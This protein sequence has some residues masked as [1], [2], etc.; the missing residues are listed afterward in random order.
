MTTE[1]VPGRNAGPV[2]LY[3]LSTC[4]WCR[5]TRQLLDQMGVA[6]DYEYVDLVHGVERTA[7]MDLV[8]RWNHEGSFPT[9]VINNRAIVGFREN[10]IR[11]AL[12]PRE[13][14]R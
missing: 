10:E 3:A 13:E 2:T 12:K 1:H 8:H 4:G 6:Y 9:L 14:N 5:K 11:G 7:V